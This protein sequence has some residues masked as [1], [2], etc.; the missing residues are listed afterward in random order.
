VGKIRHVAFMI[1]EPKKVSEFYQQGFGFEECYESKTGSRMVLDG[2]F[3]VA[4]LQ[5]RP[6]ASAVVG[7]HREDGGEA[8]QTPGINHF[9]FVIDNLDETLAKIGSDLK[10]GQNPQD[11]RPAEM[12]V[13]DP[14]GNS[15][16]LSA[17]GYFGRE[18]KRLPAVRQVVVQAD[19]P[20]EVAEFYQENLGLNEVRKIS[21]GSV[22]LG[23]GH[24]QL[25]LVQEGLTNKRGIQSLGLQIEDWDEV[26]ERFHAMGQSLQV[27]RDKNQDITVRD[28][29]GNLLVLSLKGWEA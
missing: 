2:L 10:Q 26:A 6:N 14:W 4:L 25:A 5:I 19:R 8:N 18:E 29:E 3:N 22:I 20:N 11:G 27:P 23:D 7:T 24:I 28:P 1:K 15:F 9:G 16:D 21:D 17:R 12:R 13:Y